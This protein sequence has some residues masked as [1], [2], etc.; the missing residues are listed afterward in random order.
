MRSARRRASTSLI[1]M[2]TSLT[3][4]CSMVASPGACLSFQWRFPFNVGYVFTS[5]HSGPPQ[6]SRELRAGLF[7]ADSGAV[8]EIFVILERSACRP[9]SRSAGASPPLIR[10]EPT[11]APLN[12][13]E[14]SEH[15]S[16]RAC[17]KRMISCGLPRR[18]RRESRSRLDLNSRGASRC[19]PAGEDLVMALRR[20]V[21]DRILR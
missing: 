12:L 8:L 9:F 13:L 10:T 18:L 5:G 4:V 17:G 19:R 7:A 11:R 2:L 6:G 3:A 15:R 21:R 20:R 14:N 16:P 1:G